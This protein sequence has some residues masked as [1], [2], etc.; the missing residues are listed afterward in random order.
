MKTKIIGIALMIILISPIAVFAA[1]NA[2]ETGGGGAVMPTTGGGSAAGP[3]VIE[4]IVKERMTVE[5]G[6]EF[7]ITLN[8]KHLEWWKVVD[9]DLEYIERNGDSDRCA[10]CP[11]CPCYIDFGFKALE[12]GNTIIKFERRYEDDTLLETRHIY[13]TIE[14]DSCPEYYTCPDGTQVPQCEIVSAN[15]GA[16]CLCKTSPE[17]QCSRRI[18]SISILTPRNG[19]IVSGVVEIQ[20]E[21][22]GATENM[23][24]GINVESNGRITTLEPKYCA[25]LATEIAIGETS[26]E[27]GMRCDYYWDSSN[28]EGDIKICANVEDANGGSGGCTTV[29]TGSVRNTLAI[30]VKES[31][32]Y[33]PIKGASVAVE[34]IGQVANG[35]IRRVTKSGTTYWTDENGEVTFTVNVGE[36]YKIT[37]EAEGYKTEILTDLTIGTDVESQIGIVKVV[38]LESITPPEFPKEQVELQ[39]YKGWNLV[40]FQGET[41]NLAGTCAEERKPFG[42]V[43]MKE[44]GKY[45]SLQEV[46]GRLGNRFIDYIAKNA[47]WLYSYENCKLTYEVE[48]Y[49]SFNNIDLSSGWNLVPVTTDMIGLTLEDIEG[50]CNIKTVYTWNAET[51]SWLTFSKKM[52]FARDYLH[53]GVLI[54]ANNACTLGGS[55]L[56]PPA[57][58][59]E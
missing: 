7:T 26:N 19:E 57:F 8:E 24:M 40:S 50:S 1:E 20:A 28:Y 43:Y 35:E 32:T 6:E 17:N 59:E 15:G 12:R 21:A 49:T 41:E 22:L 56:M 16:G 23:K 13:I 39:L 11:G 34:S 4:G 38:Y 31:E 58:P 30:I 18:P 5:V 42:F 54:K 36:V 48:E 37:A 14:E 51:Q 3:L 33:E 47:L 52:E 29:Y 45:L 53:K 9:Y 25:Y 27:H 10:T 2:T 46:S 55:S 44:S